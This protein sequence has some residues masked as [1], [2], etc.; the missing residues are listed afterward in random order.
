MTVETFHLAILDKNLPDGSGIDLVREIHDADPTTEVILI[1]GYASVESA[2]SALSAGVYDY[3]TKPFENINELR[4]KVR[5]ALEKQRLGQEKRALVDFLETV[6]ASMGTGLVVV[7]QTGHI[8]AVNPP[9]RSILGLPQARSPF[10]GSGP[11]LS[12]YVGEQNAHL[13][14]TPTPLVDGHYAQSEV[15]IDLPEGQRVEVGFTATPLLDS[16]GDSV[17]VV[18]NCRDLAGVKKMREQERRK[19]RLAALGEMSARIAH[20]IR[21]PLVSID[22]VVQLLKEELGDEQQQD[23]QLISKEVGR[24]HAIVSDFLGFAR[25]KRVQ[26]TKGN[27]SALLREGAR[28]I[29]PQYEEKGVTLEL[30]EVEDV[31]GVTF[32]QNGMKQVLLNVLLNALDASPE[33]SQVTASA[34]CEDDFVFLCVDDEGTGISEE[35][36]ESLFHPFFSTKSRGTGLGLAVCKTIVE[37]HGGKIELMNRPQGGARARVVL[38]LEHES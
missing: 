26:A 4:N 11:A 5:H 31:P 16:K 35:A 21:N 13:L 34:G 29:T 3:I 33:G 6:T 32:D 18:I 25:P 10:G 24:L 38:P 37:E 36:Q 9:A 2:V 23:L 7:D 20:E 30:S 19:E 1:T 27:L 8:Q 17:G 15:T 14:C 22:S 12:E 28:Q